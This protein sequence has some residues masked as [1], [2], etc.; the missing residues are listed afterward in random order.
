MLSP[1]LSYSGSK[2]RLKF[3]GNF[4][5]QDKGTF[6]HGT[7]VNIYIAYDLKST[8]NYNEN[9]TLENCFFG[10]V[11]LTKKLIL[12]STNILHMVL[13]LMELFHVQVVDLVIMQ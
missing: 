6:N 1:E 9:I 10:A 4:I 5:K 11:E 3:N 8:L 12:I 2:A 13:D 7:I